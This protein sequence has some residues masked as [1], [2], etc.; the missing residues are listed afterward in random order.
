MLQNKLL[1]GFLDNL[2]EHIKVA[3]QKCLNCKYDYN[4]R[5]SDFREK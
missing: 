2:F 5:Y 3:N 4:I 1:F